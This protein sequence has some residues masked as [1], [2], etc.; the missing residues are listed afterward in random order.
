M[1]CYVM[2]GKLFICIFLINLSYERYHSQME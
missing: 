2:R 1:E